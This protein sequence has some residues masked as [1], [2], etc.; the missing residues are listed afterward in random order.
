MGIRDI[1]TERV[2][3]KNLGLTFDQ[4]VETIGRSFT[5]LLVREAGKPYRRTQM[6]LTELAQIGESETL[7]FKSSMRWDYNQ[8]KVNK[9]LEYAVAKTLCA[10]MNTDGGT[11]IIGVNNKGE[12][13]GLEKDLATL[14]KRDMDGFELAFTNVVNTYLG[15]ENRSLCHLKS[16]ER[17]GKEIAMLRVERSRHPVY[18]GAG[19]ELEFYV[20]SG[21]SSQPLN[22]R[23][24]L[25]YIQ[26][27]EWT[28]HQPA[29]PI[30]AK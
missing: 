14:K 27:H 16:E 9:D 5:A 11:L 25:Q 2:F 10:F 29:P 24:A 13:I 15:R 23:E 7:E 8:G 18:V 1:Q 12:P 6:R 28:S 3:E 17:D 30:E 19:S 21:N 22:I 20:R 26:E 4:L